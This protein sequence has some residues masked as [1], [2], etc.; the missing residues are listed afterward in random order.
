MCELVIVGRDD[1]IQLQLGQTSRPKV[2]AEYEKFRLFAAVRCLKRIPAYQ[3]LGFFPHH[4]SEGAI[5]TGG[6]FDSARR[7]IDLAMDKLPAQEPSPVAQSKI[8]VE[9]DDDGPP[10]RR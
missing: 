6:F 3:D 1:I 7:I 10:R 2:I 4:I 9:T 8:E 5:I